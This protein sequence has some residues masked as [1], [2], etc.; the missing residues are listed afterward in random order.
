M[1]L[2]SKWTHIEIASYLQ[3]EKFPHKTTIAT[4]IY[5]LHLV[6]IITI[7]SREIQQ[8]WTYFI[9]NI[10]LSNKTLFQQY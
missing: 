6:L 5:S 10:T 9:F 3:S 8:D 4:Y 7:W 1:R 2:T